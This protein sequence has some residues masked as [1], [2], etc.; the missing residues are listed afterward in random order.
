M[1]L[2]N[3]HGFDTNSSLFSDIKR[4]SEM[5]ESAFLMEQYY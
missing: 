4:D 2:N 5:S 3:F 1:L